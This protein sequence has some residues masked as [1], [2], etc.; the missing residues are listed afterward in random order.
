MP[1]RVASR[2]YDG[3]PGLIIVL[4]LLSIS[5]SLSG[6]GVLLSSSLHSSRP[7]SSEGRGEGEVDV[8]CGKKGREE[9]GKKVRQFEG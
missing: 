6:L 4:L 8:L 2:S 7:G 3:F 1:R 9:R 5:T